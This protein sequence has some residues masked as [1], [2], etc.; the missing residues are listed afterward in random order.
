MIGIETLFAGRD[1]LLGRPFWYDEYCTVLIASHGN[2]LDSLGALAMGADYNP[3]L[4]YLGLRALH[5]VGL[6]FTPFALR[7]LALATVWIALTVLYCVLAPNFGRWRSAIGLAAAWAV[8]TTLVGAFDVRFYGPMLMLCAIIA[9]VVDAPGL[10]VRRRLVL[11]CIVCAALC[12]LHWF[13][14][15][16]VGL[17]AAA[18]AF[19][20]RARRQ[21]LPRWF[22]GFAGG[23]LAT[24]V[25][26][27]LLRGQRHALTV[28]TWIPRAT[29]AGVSRFIGDV[30]DIR[31]LLG[32]ATAVAV[33][34][35]FARWSRSRPSAVAH[36]V[37]ASNPTTSRP[38]GVTAGVSVLAAYSVMPIVLVAFSVAFQPSL[39]PR[40]AIA[41][42]LGISVLACLALE[43]IPEA[44]VW[45]AGALFG[46]FGAEHV[47]GLARA[48]M[49]FSADVSSTIVA[50]GASLHLGDA[51]VSLTAHGMYPIER[52][53]DDSG[54]LP[55]LVD[56]DSADS[57]CGP[58][59]ANLCNVVTVLRDVARIHSRI[60]GHPRLARLDSLRRLSRLYVLERTDIRFRLTD[61]ALAAAMFPQHTAKQIAPGVYLMR[62]GGEP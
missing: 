54:F 24:L 52:D 1:D 2:W 51:P 53:L 35:L 16:L 4:L 42:V 45:T 39:V 55:V 12:S 27:P 37:R 21:R 33:V 3:P 30:Y 49:A 26:F 14:I 8:P 44:C 43:R 10:S 60:Y 36:L 22:L 57:P 38:G 25:W 32:V 20:F 56:F 28:P 17:A 6:P 48:E 5:Q 19:F 7:C 46:V 31:E 50:V 41:T 13:G 23:P 58:L 15:F 29:V 9:G 18:V 11:L 47:F 59:G 61:S 62:R 34:A 40:Y